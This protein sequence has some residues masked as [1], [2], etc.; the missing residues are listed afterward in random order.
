MAIV[1]APQVITD[2]DKAG[3]IIVITTFFLTCIWLALFVRI[4]VRLKVNGPWKSDDSLVAAAT[5]R[6]ASFSTFQLHLHFL[7]NTSTCLTVSN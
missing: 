1:P 5:V 4:Y 2:T 3:L 6:L 7:L